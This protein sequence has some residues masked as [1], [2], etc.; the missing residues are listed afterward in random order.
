MNLKTIKDKLNENHEKVFSALDMNYEVMSDNVYCTCPVHDGSDNKTAFSFS[1]Q[2]GIWK[3]WTRD[4]Q[5]EYSND[6]FGLIQ[7][8][9]SKTE[10]REVSFKEVLKWSCDLL[11]VQHTYSPS[12]TID[13][14]YEDDFV[15]LVKI[16]KSPNKSE[17][18]VKP[19]SIDCTLSCPSE[20]F[21]NRGFNKKTMKYFGIGDCYEPCSMKERAVIPI[22]NENGKHIVGL[23]GR[24]VKEYKTPKFLFH[25]KGFDKRFYFYNYHRAIKKAIETSCLYIMEGQGDV[26]RMYEAGV[27]NAVSILGKTITQQQQERLLSLPI[28]NLIILTDNDQAGRESKVQIKRQLGRMF[29]LTFPK[30]TQKD[31]G[32]MTTK[33]IKNNI[34]AKLKGTY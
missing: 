7:G 19:I 17:N 29:R 25:P 8:A 27:S 4:C 12:S 9:L 5:N 14:E 23:I 21:V 3:C 10:G 18:T 28:T 6:I 1:V 24:S 22:H 33:D 13:S 16:I 15:D 11:N 32:D 20:Y 2:K 31:I 34:L 26:W 30:L